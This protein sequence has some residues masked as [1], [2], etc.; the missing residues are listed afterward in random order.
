MVDELNERPKKS[1]AK[2]FQ[3]NIK[4]GD[5]KLREELIELVD[6][7]GEFQDREDWVRYMIQLMKLQDQKV[8]AQKYSQEIRDFENH[9]KRLAEI[10]VN[11]VSRVMFEEEE[12]NTKIE[13]DTQQIEQL[14]ARILNLTE[15][16]QGFG[17]Q[18]EA[19][20]QQHQEE[21]K[22]AKELFDEKKKHLEERIEELQRDLAKSDAFAEQQTK[23]IEDYQQRLMEKDNELSRYKGLQKE[24]EDLKD[25]L[26]EQREEFTSEIDKLKKTISEKDR[27]IQDLKERVVSIELEKERQILEVKQKSQEQLAKANEEYNSRVRELLDEIHNLKT[28]LN[29]P[30]S[31]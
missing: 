25:K 1:N 27:E 9:T 2:R 24:N 26:F 18:F 8:A 4:I 6:R 20:E 17:D 19:Q 14:Q 5:E 10:F 15:Q 21:L 22:E 23:N 13:N 12:Y 31:E 28:N 11:F 3:F 16:V 29:P 7:N 30:P